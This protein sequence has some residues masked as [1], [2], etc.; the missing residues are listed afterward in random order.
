MLSGTYT[1]LVEHSP[2]RDRG[3][4]WSA[5]QFLPVAMDYD[6]ALPGQDL[7]DASLGKVDDA[8]AY[9]GLIS[10]R[11]GQTPEFLGIAIRI[12]CH[13]PNWNFGA[14][15]NWNPNLHVHHARRSFGSEGC[16]P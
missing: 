7:I 1:E 2:R 6:A 14:Q 8:D 5:E 9:V 11:Y 10:Y 4:D 12:V 15:S 3:D 16:S 13:S